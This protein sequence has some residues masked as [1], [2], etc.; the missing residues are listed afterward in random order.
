MGR[1]FPCAP[2]FQPKQYALHSPLY[3]KDNLFFS[4][5][6]PIL[7][8]NKSAAEAYVWFV[9]HGSHSS[10]D[11]LFE[12]VIKRQLKYTFSFKSSHRRCSVKGVLKNFAK[13]HTK[14]PVLQRLLLQ[15]LSHGMYLLQVFRSATLL[16]RDFRTGASL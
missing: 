12:Y 4:L 14:T 6:F 2:G 9:F 16:K 5:R 13:F 3:N 8:S 7:I 10:R 11:F 15:F 1:C